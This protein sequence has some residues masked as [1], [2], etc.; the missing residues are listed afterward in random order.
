MSDAASSSTSLETP[1]R[2]RGRGRGRSNRGG[3]GKYLRARGRSRGF[4]RPAEFSK[5]LL[6]EGEG[7]QDEDEDDESAAERAA[8]YSRR[9]LGTNADRYAEPEPELDSDGEPIIEPEVDLSRFM[10]KQ[11]L[12]DASLLAPGLEEN[13]RDDDD[14]DTSLAHISSKPLSLGSGASRK[15]K[16]EQIVWDDELDKMSQEKAAA[17]AARDLKSRLRA[18]S[19][20]M[21]GKPTMIPKDRSAEPKYIDAPALPSADAQPKDAKADMQDFLDDLL[22]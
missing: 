3:L 4:G 18:K 9:Q 10:E 11:R 20:K 16:V 12:A 8:K 21:R 2:G 15:G 1:A 22:G 5:R 7:P 13:D 17:E 14:V 19:E 6:L